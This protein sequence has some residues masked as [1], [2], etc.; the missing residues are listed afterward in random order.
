MNSEKEQKL[1]EELEA[2]AGRKML[3][4]R[5]F[6][7]LAEIILQRTGETISATTL[8]RFWGY[9][10]AEGGRTTAV[11]TLNQLSHAACGKDWATY[12]VMPDTEEKNEPSSDFIVE[13][14][15]LRPASLVFGDQVV[16][17]WSPNRRVLIEFQGEDVF[18]VLE[19]EHSKLEVGDTFHC[20]QFIASEPLMC[21]SLIRPGMATTNN[22]CGKQGGI[23]WSRPKK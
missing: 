1:R 12:C 11:H 7:A 14:V 15:L 10:E 2:L 5:D 20:A 18:R 13:G 8:R 4:R 17:T 19:S 21:H 16:L 22:I 9:Q 3:T 6:D 23:R